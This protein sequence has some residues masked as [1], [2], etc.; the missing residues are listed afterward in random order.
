MADA[1]ADALEDALADALADTLAAALAVALADTLEITV[2]TC[3]TL[4]LHSWAMFWMLTLSP[5]SLICV[6]LTS[7]CTAVWT[8]ATLPSPT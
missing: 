7:V 8:Q 6:L 2:L 3:S 5:C 1:V 4:M